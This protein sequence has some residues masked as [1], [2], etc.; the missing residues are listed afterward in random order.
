MASAHKRSQPERTEDAP[1]EVPP[2]EHAI[3]QCQGFR[4]LAMR[5]KDGKWRDSK[6]KDLPDVVRVIER[7]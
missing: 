7:L 4:C 2:G 3:V 1:K 6:G 5:G